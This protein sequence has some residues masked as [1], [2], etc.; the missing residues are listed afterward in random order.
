[1]NERLSTPISITTPAEGTPLQTFLENIS[2]FT[3][4]NFVI[5]DAS[6]CR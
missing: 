6:R 2:V 1:M 5:A 3:D 4:L